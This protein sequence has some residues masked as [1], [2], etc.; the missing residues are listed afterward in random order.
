MRDPL[1]RCAI[2]ILLAGVAG[3]GLLL[4][5]CGLKG[6]LYHPDEGKQ[7]A[8]KHKAPM[9]D[10]APAPQAQK[11]PGAGP[12][13]TSPAIDPDRPAEPAPGSP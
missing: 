8:G 11:N 2:G 6:P 5:G 10:R 1:L 13:S 3:A 9:S 4:A 7:P 12:A